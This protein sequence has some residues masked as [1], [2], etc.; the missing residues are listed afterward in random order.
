MSPSLSLSLSV[1]LL[2]QQTK[3]K[4]N[5]HPINTVINTQTQFKQEANENFVTSKLQID[6]KA[7]PVG[8]VRTVAGIPP[9]T[10]HYIPTTKT[11]GPT[12]VLMT[13]L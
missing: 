10:T 3:W 4:F 12:Y 9:P 2:S 13:D 6:K 7:L 5:Y 8:P 1:S 11:E